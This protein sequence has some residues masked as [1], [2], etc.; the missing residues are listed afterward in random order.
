MV[1]G[2]LP[3]SVS[4]PYRGL[5]FLNT[6][7]QNKYSVSICFRPLPGTYISQYSIVE[8][9]HYLWVSVPYRGL[10]F[11]NLL[12]TVPPDKKILKKVSVPYRGLI[13]LNFTSLYSKRQFNVS[14]PYRGLIFLNWLCSIYCKDKF[15]SVPYRGL[16]F[17]NYK[18]LVV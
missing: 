2:R 15:V 5:I 14:V 1:Y 9:L 6:V 7:E 13:F 10:I 18:Q 8:Y 3:D 17:L 16:I 4:V 11:L 12:P